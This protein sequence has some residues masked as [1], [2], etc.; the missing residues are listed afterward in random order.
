MEYY[1]IIIVCV[2]SRKQANDG[3]ALSFNYNRPT[4]SQWLHLNSS[5]R[6]ISPVERNFLPAHAP[7]AGARFRFLPKHH[8]KYKVT[9]ILVYD[10]DSLGES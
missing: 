7:Y 4:L 10:A 9:R 2:S 1:L 3:L 6:Y 5:R 8:K